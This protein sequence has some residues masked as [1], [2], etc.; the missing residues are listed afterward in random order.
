MTYLERLDHLAQAAQ[1]LKDIPSINRA[2]YQFRFK[3]IE[4]ALLAL[5]R[6]CGCELKLQPERKLKDE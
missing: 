3:A 5:A 2:A 4:T 6:E 1:E